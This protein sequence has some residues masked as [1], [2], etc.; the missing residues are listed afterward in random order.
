MEFHSNKGNDLNRI[1]KLFDI[2]KRG[3]KATIS[4]MYMFFS[5]D[6]AYLEF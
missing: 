6:Y 5:F 2:R 3:Q 4:Q 1:S